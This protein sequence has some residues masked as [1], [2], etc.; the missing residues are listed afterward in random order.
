[1]LHLLARGSRRAVPSWW[2]TIGLRR[3]TKDGVKKGIGVISHNGVVGLSFRIRT[4]N[5][6]SGATHKHKFPDRCSLSRDDRPI[7][8]QG[9]G[10][11]PGGIPSGIVFDVPQDIVASSESPLNLV[12]SSLGG[13]F[14]KGIKNRKGF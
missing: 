4:Q 12:T 9:N 13:T 10:I 2:Q 14:P 5:E 7:T 3:G 1:M 11:K 8:F 6:R